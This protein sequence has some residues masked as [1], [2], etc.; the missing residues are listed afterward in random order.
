MPFFF[1]VISRKLNF[2]TPQLERKIQ[3]MPFSQNSTQ[4]CFEP[5]TDSKLKFIKKQINRKSQKNDTIPRKYALGNNKTFRF[6]F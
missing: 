5:K 6:N 1:F 3:V 4:I 2:K